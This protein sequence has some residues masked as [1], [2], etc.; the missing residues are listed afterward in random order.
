[1]HG[2]WIQA[3]TDLNA[4]RDPYRDI[5]TVWIVAGSLAVAGLLWGGLLR[6][7]RSV[8][9]L[10]AICLGL[11]AVVTFWY[12][13]LA[14]HRSLTWMD[15]VP[16][17]IVVVAVIWTSVRK[18]RLRWP[19]PGGMALG[20][21]AGYGCDGLV[22]WGW[23]VDGVALTIILWVAMVPILAKGW[24]NRL[25]G[26]LALLGAVFGLAFPDYTLFALRRQGLFTLPNPRWPFEW[27][28][29]TTAAVL[30]ATCMVLLW[31]HVRTRLQ[32]TRA[33]MERNPLSLD[34]P[35]RP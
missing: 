30:G 10:G 6:R 2:R 7:R 34:G 22:L 16:L 15:R 20:T 1:M 33:K 21:V 23:V 27:L 28:Y 14:V 24:V 29:P 35:E 19:W 18:G 17:G 32:A 31:I 13:A 5:Q 25:L 4:L 9:A 12:P 8:A 3:L 11:A 26:L